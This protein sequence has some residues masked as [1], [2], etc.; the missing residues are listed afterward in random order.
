MATY[1]PAADYL[2]AAPLVT[3]RRVPPSGVPFIASLRSGQAWP[4]DVAPEVGQRYLDAGLMAPAGTS[5]GSRPVIRPADR[6][7]G[8]THP[9]PGPGSATR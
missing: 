3:L 4:K 1:Q 8:R 9:F 6:G 2:V 7:G 5:L